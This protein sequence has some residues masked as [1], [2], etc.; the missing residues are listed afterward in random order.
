MTLKEMQL[1]ATEL[2]A[3]GYHE[4]MPVK[5]LFEHNPDL[6]GDIQEFDVVG[7][8]VFAKGVFLDVVA[9]GDSHAS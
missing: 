9:E 3:E 8:D 2:L 5:V 1:R 6:V 4:D 7:F